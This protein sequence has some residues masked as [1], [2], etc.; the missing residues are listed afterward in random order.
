MFVREIRLL[1]E[2]CF[3]AP[4]FIPLL[5]PF[6]ADRDKAIVGLATFLNRIANRT[7][8]GSVIAMILYC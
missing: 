2:A 4:A 1:V 8:E 5:L 3:V 7:Q 6:D